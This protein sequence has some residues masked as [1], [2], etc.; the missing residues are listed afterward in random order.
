MLAALGHR[1]FQQLAGALL[2]VDLEVGPG[3]IQLGPHPAVI[4]IHIKAVGL[5][6]HL[7]ETVQPHIQGE[8]L[9]GFLLRAAGIGIGQQLVDFNEV[10]VLHLLAGFHLPLMGLHLGEGILEVRQGQL[11]GIPL[12]RR[13]LGGLQPEL[14]QHVVHIVLAKPRLV[15]VRRLGGKLIVGR[16]AKPGL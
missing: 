9:I 8:A 16:L 12:G 3:Q 13:R 15:D 5:R 1:L 11:A 2:V 14:G 6:Q 4:G 7:G 10:A